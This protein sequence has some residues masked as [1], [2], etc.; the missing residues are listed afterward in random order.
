MLPELG[1]GYLYLCPKRYKVQSEIQLFLL[2]VESAAG[3]IHHSFGFF[4][5]L[6][7]LNPPPA[8]KEVEP[9]FNAC[10]PSGYCSVYGGVKF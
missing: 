6:T 7:Q 5:E 1:C 9:N 8:G 10:Q 4:I 3:N 2:T